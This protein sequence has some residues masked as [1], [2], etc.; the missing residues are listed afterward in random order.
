MAREFKLP[1]IGEGVHEGEIVKWLVKEGD[2]VAVDQPLVEIM[3]DKATVEIPSAH[4]GQVE[5][6]KAKEGDVVKV[7]QTIMLLGDGAGASAGAAKSPAK[8][9]PAAVASGEVDQDEPPKAA[10]RPTPPV[11]PRPAAQAPRPAPQPAR[12]AVVPQANAEYVANPGSTRATPA[13]R[14]LARDLGVDLT[15]VPAS[16]PNGRVTKEDV[17]RYGGATSAGAPV[18]VRPSSALAKATTNLAA[19]ARTRSEPTELETLV[20]FRGIRRKI[21]EAMT[22]SRTLIP[23]FTYVDEV[24]VSELVSFRKEMK[25][26]AEKQG[27]KLTYLPFIVKAL[28]R[29]LREY[30]SL[31]ATLDEEGGNI[32]VKN[33]YNIGIAVDTEDGLMVPNVKNADQKSILQIAAEITDLAERARSRKLT[34]EDMHGGT[35]TITNPGPIGGLVTAPVI[36]W[37]EVAILAVHKIYRRPVVKDDDSIGIADLMYLSIAVDHRVVDGATAARFMNIMIDYLS[38]PKKMLLD[39]A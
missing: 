15:T 4:A 3:T 38:S 5:S 33:Y 39:M 19:A 20:P 26:E 18:P 7:G 1:D 10:A 31:N 34:P 17:Q 37:P 13:T 27:V 11:A 8:P 12:Q 32:I 28:I 21:S 9:A 22:R 35:F 30:P 36:N 14:R 25:A 6:L 2:A 16:G 24:N 23:E 29:A